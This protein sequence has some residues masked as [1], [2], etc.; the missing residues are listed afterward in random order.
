MQNLEMYINDRYNGECNWFE[1]EVNQ[2]N[3]IHRISNVVNNK[4]YLSGKHKIL[5]REDMKWKGNE[6]YTKKLIIQQAKTIL[7][8]HST[9][10]LGKSLSLIGSE[11][12]VKIYEYIYRQA[13]YSDIDFNILTSCLKYADV[14]EYVYIENG[15]IKSKLIA[16]ED[17]YPIYSEDDGSY[18]GFVE[19]WTSESNKVSYYYVYYMD[20]VQYWSNEGG[21][22]RKLN[23]SV[24]VSGLPI[25]YSNSESNYHNF[26]I[27]M[28]QDIKPLLDEMEDILS[29]MSDS[30]Y[31]LSL[32]PIPVSV[33]QR[34]EGAIPSDAVGYSINLDVGEF[35]FKNAE[36]DYN[37]I[38]L[39][40]DKIQQ[41]LNFIAH[42]PSIAMGN[43]NVANVSEVSLKLLYQLADVYAMLNERWI[44]RGLKERFNKIDKLLSMQNVN[45]DG[46]ID[47]EFNYSRPVNQEELLSNIEKQRNMGAISI[48]TIIEKS[49][50]TKDKIQELERLRKEGNIIDNN[51]N[52]E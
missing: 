1:K 41:Q 17:G 52:L 28:L 26:G 20:K 18:I 46:Y 8:F 38:K 19:H 35:D 36:L 43:T 25:H 14:Y 6:Y 9:Y 5:G 32:N 47:V 42:M 34:I 29:K 37:S 27:S 23:E 21:E 31:T 24:N 7:N 2:I 16:S 50:I 10:L 22:L 11:E 45:V 4:E 33:G 15:I 48:E 51:T 49:D 3:H 44:R 12:K 13:N 40:I 30:I 39:Y